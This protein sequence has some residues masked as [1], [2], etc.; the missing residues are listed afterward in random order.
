MIYKIT[1]LVRPKYNQRESHEET[2]A[3]FKDYIKYSPG[4]EYFA[5]DI[6]QGVFIVEEW[7]K[8]EVNP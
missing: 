8:E 5:H 2:D 7:T 4:I 6:T 1:V 3:W